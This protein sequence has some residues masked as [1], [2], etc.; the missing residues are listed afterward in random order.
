MKGSC[1]TKSRSHY[2]ARVGISNGVSRRSTF[3]GVLELEKDFECVAGRRNSG[4]IIVRP[5]G[6]SD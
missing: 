6:S 1:L 4:L 5:K 3:L 2:A